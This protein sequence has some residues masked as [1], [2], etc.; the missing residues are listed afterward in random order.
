MT[1]TTTIEAP[2]SVF[3][4]YRDALG[5][6]RRTYRDYDEPEINREAVTELRHKIGYET[7][8]FETGQIHSVEL[9]DQEIDLL[10]SGISDIVFDCDS[11]SARKRAHRAADHLVFS[12]APTEA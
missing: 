2:S 12:E 9:T 1:K 7:D 8:G 10:W 4:T 5:L 3:R 6:L 11:K